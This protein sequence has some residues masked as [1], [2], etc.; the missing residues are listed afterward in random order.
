MGCPAVC[1]AFVLSVC[2]RITISPY[3]VATHTVCA[4]PASA[5]ISDNL[6]PSVVP[7]NITSFFTLPFLPFLPG[8]LFW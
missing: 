4:I 6:R 3:S 7:A 1:I 5:R 8:S 2:S